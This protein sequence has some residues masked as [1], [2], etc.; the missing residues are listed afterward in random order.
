MALV[1]KLAHVGPDR[2]LLVA[3]LRDEPGLLD[4]VTPYESSDTA[5]IL[6]ISDS[7]AFF[8]GHAFGQFHVGDAHQRDAAAGHHQV[9]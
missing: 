8:V 6:C 4:T 7:L 3:P 1:R 9:V 2:W 5:S